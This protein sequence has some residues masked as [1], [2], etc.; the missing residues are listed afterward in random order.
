[1]A[2][3]IGLVYATL[4]NEGIDIK[5]MNT[6][7]AVAKYNELQ[8]K[9]GGKSGEKEATPAENRRLEQKNITKTENNNKTKLKVSELEPT[10]QRAYYDV[11]KFINKYGKYDALLEL[12]VQRNLRKDEM[13]FIV[14]KLYVDKVLDDFEYKEQT[15][16]LKGNDLL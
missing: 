9:T 3:F 10:A 1:M 7:E 4:K 8:E 6:D 11:E 5:D 14:D 16:Y 2:N 12:A 13:K 15:E